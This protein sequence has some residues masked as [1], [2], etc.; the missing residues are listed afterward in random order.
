MRLQLSAPI[1]R[2]PDWRVAFVRTIYPPALRTIS[3]L[4]Q[5][6]ARFGASINLIE[7]PSFSRGCGHGTRTIARAG[8]DPNTSEPSAIMRPRPNA[9]GERSSRASGRDRRAACWSSRVA[10]RPQASYWPCCAATRVSIPRRSS[11]V[12]RCLVGGI[13]QQRMSQGCS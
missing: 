2:N 6:R 9:R 13:L 3:R 7:P 4:N 8:R 12:Q 11:R 10:R 5:L 1:D